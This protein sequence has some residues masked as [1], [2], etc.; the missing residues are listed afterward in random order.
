MELFVVLIIG[1]WIMSSAAQAQPKAKVRMKVTEFKPKSRMD[2]PSVKY[3][4][5]M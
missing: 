4:E 3:L 2:R 1:A 5:D